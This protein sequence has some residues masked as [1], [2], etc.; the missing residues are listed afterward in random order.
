M[1]AW[2]DIGHGVSIQVLTVR[3]EK[4]PDGVAYQHPDGKGEMCRGYASFSPPWTDGWKVESLD[5]L[6]ISPSLLCRVCGHHGF[7]RDGKWIPA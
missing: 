6:T 1:S 2:K 4:G 5:P 7:I 3:D